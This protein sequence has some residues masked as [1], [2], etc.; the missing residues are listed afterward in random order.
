MFPRTGSYE[1][2]NYSLMTCGTVAGYAT[3]RSAN[4]T[5]LAQCFALAHER[6]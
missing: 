2:M 1:C 4:K 3:T 5:M 6:Q